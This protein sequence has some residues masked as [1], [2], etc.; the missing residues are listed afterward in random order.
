[1][2]AMTID[3]VE[4]V[5]LQAH[6]D[7]RGSFVEFYRQSWLP[8][9]R[10]ALQG[11]I[12]RSR[13]GVLRGI[14]LH[15]LQWDYWF[16]LS[17]RAFV[18]LADLRSGSPTESSVDTMDLS[19]EEQRGLFIPPGVAHG[20]FARTDL[21]MLYLVD[22]AFDGSDELAVAWDD[23][24]LAIAWPAREPVLSDR[25]RANPSLDDIRRDPPRYQPLLG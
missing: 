5:E 1:M 3:G 9:E 19:D 10:S 4:L 8:T 6:E 15:R 12:S 23:P 7:P 14:H 22:R 16:V 13:A 18:A 24:G 2:V 25:D 11:N 17:G 21:V 20:F